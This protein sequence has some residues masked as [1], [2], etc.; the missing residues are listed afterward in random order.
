MD[1]LYGKPA[2][3]MWERE[4]HEMTGIVTAIRSNP[5]GIVPLFFLFKPPVDCRNEKEGAY[6]N[7]KKTRGIINKTAVKEGIS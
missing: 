5:V 4:N 3:C 2:P 7:Y 6:C 1:D